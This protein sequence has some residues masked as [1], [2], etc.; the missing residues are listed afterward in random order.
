MAEIYLH[1]VVCVRVSADWQMYLH[2]VVCVRVS[3]GVAAAAAAAAATKP[4][5]EQH[6]AVQRGTNNSANL[7]NDII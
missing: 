4:R 2:I 6:A 3:A 7:L 5:F 1:I